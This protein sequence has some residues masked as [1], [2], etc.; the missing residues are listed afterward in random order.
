MEL[1]IL[2]VEETSNPQPQP[3][4]EPGTAPS[5]PRKRRG[6]KR[7]RKRGSKNRQP[8]NPQPLPGASPS[9]SGN[10]SP[11]T[12]A[13][14]TS[15]EA[16]AAEF[17]RA[18]AV[19]PDAVGDSVATGELP[20]VQAV[21]APAP[22]DPDFLAIAEEYVPKAFEF[23]AAIFGSDHW[24]LGPG[25]EKI[26]VPEG[27]ACFAELYPEWRKFFDGWKIK[28]PRTAEFAMVLSIPV[29]IRG[30]QQYKIWKEEKKA[31]QPARRDPLATT[32]RGTE[33][34]ESAASS[35][36]LGN[37]G[38]ERATAWPVSSTGALG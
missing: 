1:S 12:L 24:E 26:L 25:M 31:K 14:S 20:D 23:A 3:Q 13:P 19:V 22:L 11:E 32:E 7:G 37:R 8:R 4:Q 6:K 17:E 33:M 21:A 2:P 30:M 5:S 34:P 28:Y 18:A 27:A 29:I 36:S 15:S 16:R 9:E 10:Q 35:A 38:A